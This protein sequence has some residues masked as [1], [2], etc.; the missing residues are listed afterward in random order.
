MYI[1]CANFATHE[2]RHAIV[3]VSGFTQIMIFH[4]S[5]PLTAILIKRQQH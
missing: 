2:K 3:L 1:T 5:F 4:D